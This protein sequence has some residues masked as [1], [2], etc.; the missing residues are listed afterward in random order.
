M[1][2][3]DNYGYCNMAIMDIVTFV[4][5]QMSLGNKGI[6]ERKCVAAVNVQMSSNFRF[7]CQNDES[8]SI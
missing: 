4:T 1:S 2:W 7:V 8:N 5:W 3:L 6:C